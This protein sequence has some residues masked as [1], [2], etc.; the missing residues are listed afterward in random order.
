MASAAG[1]DGGV[2]LRVPEL[3]IGP[4]LQHRQVDNSAERDRMV[5]PM[6]S[7]QMFDTHARAPRDTT[8]P[9]QAAVD[10]ELTFAR[11]RSITSSAAM[12]HKV[13]RP[14]RHNSCPRPAGWALRHRFRLAYAVIGQ[15]APERH[16]R[17][18]ALCDTLAPQ[19]KLE[20]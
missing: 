8:T 20:S 13:C 4:P 14:G 11:E 12:Q 16:G 18:F 9:Y 15:V 6:P 17:G 10:I 3:T 19:V 2:P 1:Q 5:R 7:E